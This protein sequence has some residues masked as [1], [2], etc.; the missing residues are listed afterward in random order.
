MLLVSWHFPTLKLGADLL[1]GNVITP[2][3]WYTVE[4]NLAI[5][6]ACGPAFLAFF[7]HYLPAV[8]G[9]SSHH[10]KFNPSHPKNSY[11]LG[12]VPHAASH[13]DKGTKTTVTT[14]SPYFEGNSSEEMII[15][16]NRIQKQVDVWIENDLE[17]GKQDS[18]SNAS[19]IVEK[20]ANES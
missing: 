10:T 13:M 19:T 17:T 16:P 3:I 1:A 2:M 15:M 14:R 12:S 7:R 5:F 20:A 6:I 9:G 11:P 4:V 18:R 8:F